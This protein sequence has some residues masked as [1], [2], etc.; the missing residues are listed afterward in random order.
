MSMAMAYQ[1][2]LAEKLTI[3][4]DRGRGVLLRMNYIKKT[5]SDPKLRPQYL[6]DKT[7]E[8]SVK[9][10]NKK[11]PNIDFRGNSQQ[12]LTG[13]QRQKTEVMTTM[14]S[15]YD[16]F[17]DVMEF[18]DHVYELLNTIDACQCFF[19]IAVNFDFTKNYLELIITYTSVIFML[20]RI[21]DKK[22]LV[23]MYNCAH[24]MSNGSSDPAY[25]RLSQMFMEYEQPIKKL[26]EEFGPHTKMT[27]EYLSLEVM[28]RWI[29]LGY[30]LCHSSLN[31][32]QSSQELWKMALRSGLYLT[33]VRDET[34]NIHKVTEEC[35]E[36]LKGYSKRFA[37]IKECR[38]YAIV[39]SGAMHRERRGFLRNALKELVK[40]LEDEP[41]LLGPKVLFV[42]MA[43]SFSR[44]EVLWLVRHSE[45]IPKTKTPEDYVDSQMAELLFYMERL[46]TLVTKYSR[47]VQR[48]HIQYLAQ[49]DALLLNDT[50]QNM[51]VCPEEE[52]VL[53]T[54]FV[55]TLSALTIKQV[56]NGEEFD[57]RAL[58][59]DWLR[60]QTYTSVSKAPLSLKDYPDLAKVM[61]MTQFHTKMLDNVEEML[62]E[63]SDL[64]ILCFYPRVFEK[65]F[66]QSSEEV[67]MQR[68][69]MSFPL[70][71]SHFNQTLHQLCPEEGREF[72]PGNLFWV[73]LP[74][75]S[76]RRVC[77]VFSEEEAVEKRSLRLCVTFLEEIA[78]QTSSVILEICAE[79]CNLNDQLLPKHCGQTI[80]AARN[81]KQKKQTP[82]KGEVQREKPGAESQRKD[83]AIVTNSDF[84][85]FNHIVTPT[86]FL[87]SQLEARLTKIIVR[88]AHYN[89]TTQEVG[90][91]SDL[92]AGIQAY[93][94]SLHTLSRYLSLDVTRL[95]KNVL[96]QQTQPL[97][98]YGGQ[99]IT[100][101]YT[102][103]YLEGLL[104]QASS[105]LIVH[106]PTMHCFVN[107]TIENEQ[108]FRA[109]EYSDISEMQAL[110]EL[111]GPYGL[112]FLS[113]NLMW[114][115]TSQVGE[116]KKLKR[117]PAGENVLK[118]MTIIGVILSFRTMAQDTLED[119]MQK[120][121]PYLMG[122]I[123]SLR[124]L[125]S[126]DT[127]IKVTLTVFE[128]ASAAG[129]TC[130]IDPA[131]VAAIAS[132]RTDNSSVDEE[133]K[134]TCLLLIYIAVSLPTLAL[135][136]NSYYSRH[137]GG[138]HNNIHCLATAVN[139]LSAAMFTAENKNI[140]QH[141]KEFLLV[142]S[143]TLLQLGQNVENRMDS[144][145]RDSI[146][147]LLHMIVEASPFLSQDM[148]E[149][150]FPYVLLRNAYRE[151]YKTFIITLG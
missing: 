1:Q 19:N 127:D 99:T 53:M 15:Y 36:G 112:K 64:S 121:C 29:L 42:F 129:L 92:L 9:Y 34:I 63:T 125:V 97:D 139:Q 62:H 59:L 118:R 8:A 7:M 111:I 55:S 85:V 79:Q 50:I 25:P 149:S 115:I 133:Y 3:L 48:Y 91:P 68:Y 116:L 84:T 6:T 80:S 94:A 105:N 57:F 132:M 138:H 123:E 117:L 143:S 110:A 41:G 65:M 86:E 140:E 122:P 82:K 148:L 83:R 52:S 23:A 141:L 49:F 124:D 142:A 18:R 102:N 103:W 100:T 45:N 56:E 93:T 109:E 70:A 14:S 27:C 32:N 17:I 40:V 77:R 145:N 43:L 20:S 114:H 73:V 10:I 47:V 147:L 21:E 30:L 136:P 128:L 38:E 54:S 96:L 119:I 107:Q 130:D 28:E 101:L 37:D 12:H 72:F 33:I 126:P 44:D 22:V 35:F 90:R 2:K 131:L 150:C 71:C 89:Q 51:Y 106:C 104:R 137:Y 78:R 11:F 144:K 81:K 120:H 39:N 66:S 69:L 146:Y 108:S 13:I 31:T 58:R 98:S 113:E 60:L 88:M 46:R 61:N 95:V 67:S 24:E 87:I 74:S 134:L 151:V 5:C 4:N 26:T 76:R 75:V 135:D 16:S